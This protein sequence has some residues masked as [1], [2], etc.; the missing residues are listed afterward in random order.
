M[1]LK[2]TV[3]EETLLWSSEPLQQLF[4][5][6]MKNLDP[7]SSKSPS[8]TPLPEAQLSRVLRELGCQKTSQQATPSA[9]PMPFL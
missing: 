3:C 7:V 5:F 8:Q 6:Y 1:K 4:L 2:S 9:G